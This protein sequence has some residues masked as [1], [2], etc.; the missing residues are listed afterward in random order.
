[1]VAMMR[2][3]MMVNMLNLG[4]GFRPLWGGYLATHRV[5]VALRDPTLQ[6]RTAALLVTSSGDSNP[7]RGDALP[8]GVLRPHRGRLSPRP[9]FVRSGG[10][11]LGGC[12]RAPGEA[13]QGPLPRRLRGRRP[14][15]RL[16]QR[17]LRS[18]YSFGGSSR[19]TLRLSQAGWSSAPPSVI[20]A[21]AAPF[22]LPEAA[23]RTPREAPPS[24]YCEA[25]LRVAPRL[26]RAAR[27]SPPSAPPAEQRSQGGARPPS[28]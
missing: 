18:V 14:L 4:S 11:R 13:T 10:S 1:M 3:T 2:V 23:A 8:S 20:L 7:G 15:L 24:R 26:N 6:A 25:T 27:H 22:T 19:H 12:A 16:A 5:E 28:S 17:N 9:Y 21:S